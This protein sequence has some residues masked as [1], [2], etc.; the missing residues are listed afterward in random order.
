MMNWTGADWV[1]V[2]L[3]DLWGLYGWQNIIVGRKNVN[4][5]GLQFRKIEFSITRLINFLKKLWIKL[6]FICLHHKKPNLDTPVPL[7]LDGSF[8]PEASQHKVECNSYGEL[9]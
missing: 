7:C 1:D 6:S 8:L 5:G 3:Q 4:F 9:Q 2:S